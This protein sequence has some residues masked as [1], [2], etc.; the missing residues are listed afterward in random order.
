MKM[1]HYSWI[2]LL[3]LASCMTNRNGSEEQ[4][5]EVA[6]S[7]AT[8]YFNLRYKNACNFCTGDTHQWLR[9]AAS[10]VNQAD[11][12]M[13]HKT[14]EPAHIEINEVNYTS[15][16]TAVVNMTVSNFL[17]MDSIE[18]CGHIVESATF[19]LNAVI[20]NNKWLIRMEALP[21]S[22]RRNHD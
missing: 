7:F 10:N 15:D 17:K 4:L 11:I 13:L 20:D 6:D 14:D 8:N 12:D 16:S 1:S 9:F 2:F 19:R 3:F 22:G 5:Y 18:S 21:R